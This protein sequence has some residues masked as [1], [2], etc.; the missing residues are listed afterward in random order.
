MSGADDYR[1]LGWEY[2]SLVVQ[3]LGAMLAPITFLLADGRQVSPMQ[4][5]PWTHEPGSEE[6]P[7]VL[8]RLRGDWSCVPFGYSVPSDDFAAE[9][10]PLMFPAEPDEEAHGH[11]SN[12]FWTWSGSS[13]VTCL[14]LSLDYPAASP[15]AHVERIITPD[16]KAPAVDIEFRI[17]VRKDCRLPIGL[18]PTFR[19]PLEPGA[20]TIEPARFDHGRTYPG[21]VDASSVFAVDQRFAA[22]DAV[23]TRDGSTIDA[24][25]LPFAIHTEDLLQ[26]DGIDGEVA[27]ANHAE[28]YR[29]RLTW[30][31]EY[32]PS[33]LL[34]FSN[35]GRAMPPWNGRHLALGMEP[36]CSP[37]GLGPATARC[38]QSDGTFRHADGARLRR[39][40]NLRHALP[41]RSRAALE[42]QDMAESLVKP[43]RPVF[44]DL[45]RPRRDGGERRSARRRRPS[46]RPPADRGT[47]RSRRP[48][49]SGPALHGLGRR[50]A[51]GN[52]A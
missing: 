10:A 32:F 27:L 34:W 49:R 39:R 18:H 9:W 51:I 24:S 5:A 17:H 4:V 21:N 38:R 40:R 35:R 31:K 43:N 6:L 2:G 19:L 12:Q 42:V 23:P 7:G 45:G 16:P 33:L 50:L 22:L 1:G 52:P 14:A 46:F 29:V 3:R 20:A 8:R 41:D 13:S 48:R 30:Q 25:R 37:F 44:T 11:S 47:P 36:I 15:I 28:G 26:L